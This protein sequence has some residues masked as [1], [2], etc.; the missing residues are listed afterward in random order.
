MSRPMFLRPVS[1][2]VLL[3]G[4]AASP[5]H[6]QQPIPGEQAMTASAGER[7]TLDLRTGGDL[8]ITGGDADEVRVR[9]RDR[10]GNCDDCVFWLERDEHGVT[11]VSRHQEERRR[12]R[13][14][15]LTF[16]VTVPRRYD[17]RLSSPGGAV[18][19]R[20]VEGDLRGTT[21]GGALNLSGLRGTLDLRTMGGGVTLRGSEVDGRVHTMG[22]AVL[23]EDVVGNVRGSTMGGAVTQRRVTRRDADATAAVAA[24]ARNGASAGPVRMNTMGGDITVAE[25][26][27]G[28]N[29]RTMGGRVRLETSRGE[30][31]IHT[32]GGNIHVGG[33]DGGPIHAS[34]M[35]GNVQVRMVGDPGV[36]D[37]SVEI[38]SMGGNVE[39]VVPAGLS[40]RVEIEIAYPAERAGRYS[41]RSDFPLEQREEEGGWIE[42]RNRETRTI[43]ATGAVGG[44]EHRI[45]IRT[46]DGNVTLRQR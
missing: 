26:P 44:G 27:D 25:A 17:V 11:L 9:A 12:N 34:T 19:I 6:A 22:G 39:L 5:L 32:M 30:V 18:Q 21:A 8:H 16:E 14:T 37:R 29:L 4:A 7:L 31:R 35:G 13:S 24:G 10:R 3:M 33:A 1:A 42:S 43:R 45:R 38:S 28:A 36:G 20:D 2:A 40:M 23:I 41:V 15:S 46:V